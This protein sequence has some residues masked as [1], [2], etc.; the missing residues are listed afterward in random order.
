[1]LRFV[2]NCNNKANEH[3]LIRNKHLTGSEIN[4]AKRLC[5]LDNQVVIC[6]DNKYRDATRNLNLKHDKNGMLHFK[7]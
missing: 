5:F 1:M 7:V 4:E 2:N 6:N 3:H